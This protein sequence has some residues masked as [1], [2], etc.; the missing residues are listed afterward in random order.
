M[1]VVAHVR[2]MTMEDCEAVATVRVRGWRHA[3]AGL[4]PQSYLDAMSVGEDAARRRAH[5]AEGEERITHVVAVQDGEVVG[6]G[7]CGPCRD[8][9][10]APGVCELYAIYVLPERIATGVGRALL[11]ELT[12]RAVADGFERMRLWVL[13]ENGRARRF[14]ARAGFAPDGAEEPFEVD[15]V[16]VPEVRYARALTSAG[17]G[18]H[19]G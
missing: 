10:A 12:E 5:L 19:A 14:Y 18:T 1:G 11:D 17:C 4:I 6:W 9:D 8:D 3:Y 16:A 7:C 13:K 15:G 2:G